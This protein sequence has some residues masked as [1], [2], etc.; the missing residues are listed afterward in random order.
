M[1]KLLLLIPAILFT[2]LLVAQTD[3]S[4]YYTSFDGAKIW[5]EV[6]GAGQPVLLVHGFIV[7]SSTWKKA[8]LYSDLQ[9]AG[10]KVITIDLRG[11]GLSDKPHEAASYA[12]DAEAKD[13]MGLLTSLGINKY[14]VIGY[15]RGSIIT[16]RLLVLDK[17]I[18]KAVLGGMGTDFT[19]PE[20]PRR[21][22]FYRALSGDSI[23]E[24]KGVVEYVQKS[25]LDQ[26]AL[27]LLQKEQPSTSKEALAK[28]QQPIL[29]ICG[30][31]D[32]DNGSAAALA[33]L[34]PHATLAAVPG[35][36]NNAA[37]TPQFSEAILEFLKR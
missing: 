27:A 12:N 10:Y 20:W 1:K 32:S 19:N 23:P 3:T 36:H 7:N 30:T 25:G 35:N 4:G 28:V 9:K 2:L 31:E 13:I 18:Q 8:A 29:V 34:F 15:S 6:K 26:K 14:Q 24:L 33:K 21:I 11:N 16:A 5:Y 37:S 22:M 17:R